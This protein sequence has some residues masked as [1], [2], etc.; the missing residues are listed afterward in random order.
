[1]KKKIREI[2]FGKIPVREYA[3]VSITND[4][5][6]HV[7]LDADGIRLDI[8]S[9]QWLLCLN[10]VIFGVWIEKNENH[11]TLE[12]KDSFKISFCESATHGE[13]VATIKLAFFDM[14]EESSGTL[15]LLKVKNASTQHISFIKTWMLYHK[16][17]KKPEQDFATLKSYAAAYSY[18]RKVRLIS[19]KDGDQFNIF[20]MD[21][22]GDISQNKRFVFGLRH[23]NITLAKI[24]EAKKIVVSEVPFE[25]KDIIYQLGKHH[26]TPLS[27]TALPFEVM[28]SEAFGFPIPLWSNS[29]REIKILK[30][31][32]L[33]SHMLLW[34]ETVNE[35]VLT[36]NAEA[37][38]H[39][40]FLH[41][42][43]LKSRHF[44]Y[45]EV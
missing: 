43:H 34:G 39:I 42:L 17:Y 32:N 40:H 29:Y 4:I 22:V 3:T 38:Y 27:T 5:K 2:L 33:G 37:L 28:Q 11:I 36:G 41:Y 7:Y 35:A 44:T 25:Y 15:Y 1:M 24:I 30:T 14:I 45:T 19:F 31:I 8:S 6:E 20:P 23:S 9:N 16:F 10:P 18:P 26:S 13:M 12:K 21:L